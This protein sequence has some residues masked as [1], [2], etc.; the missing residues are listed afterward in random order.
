M[1]DAPARTWLG[2]LLRWGEAVLA[3]G[4]AACIVVPALPTGWGGPLKAPLGRALL[5]V[6]LRQQWRMYSPNPQRS[7]SYMHLVAH[8][9]DGSERELDENAYERRGWGVH[10]A[11]NKTRMDIWRQYVMFHRKKNNPNRT[12]YLK[13]VCVRE[14]RRGPVPQRITMYAVTRKFTGPDQVR[15]GKP[16]LGPPKRELVTVQYCKTREVAEMIERDRLLRGLA[17]ADHG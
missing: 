4:L 8:D 5:V 13:G 2:W 14:A 3:F 12:W 15:Q 6:S 7:Q 1:T 17:E 9:P 10:F 16:G 11:W